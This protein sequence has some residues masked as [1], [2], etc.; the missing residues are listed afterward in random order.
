MLNAFFPPLFL[1]GLFLAL[2]RAGGGGGWVLKLFKNSP[3]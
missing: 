3:F 1:K 2:N